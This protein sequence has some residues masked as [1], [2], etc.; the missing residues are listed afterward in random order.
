MNVTWKEKWIAALR[1]GEFRQTKDNLHSH[2]GFCCLGVLRHIA[3][4]ADERTEEYEQLLSD[5]Q[6]QGFG[7]S[8]RIQEHLAQMNDDGESFD[9]I[10]DYIEANL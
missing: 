7:F 5:E 8:H 6:L 9:V 3:D 1:S 4:P 10:A 2:D